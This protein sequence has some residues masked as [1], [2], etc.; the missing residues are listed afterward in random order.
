MKVVLLGSGNVATHLGV[1]LKK[2]GHTLLQLFNPTRKHATAL[3]RRLNCP[4]VTRV[5][6]I[7]TTGDIYVL[8][9]KDEAI[10]PLLKQLPFVPRMIVHTSGSVG[11]EVFG[12][13]FSA[14]GV[15]YPLQTFSKLSPETPATIPFCIEAN[16]RKSE[17]LLTRMA[18][19][20][21]PLVYKMTSEQRKSVHVAA[22]FANNFSNHMFTLSEKILTGKKL[23]F[24]LMLPLIEETVERLKHARPARVQTGPARRGDLSILRAHLDWLRGDPELRDLYD[25]IS[26]SIIAYYRKEK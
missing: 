22:V 24:E 19:S 17:Q 2:K 6:A 26:K 5:S 12:K 13:N 20:L 16:S 7:D 8:A 11:L 1:L 25:R 14:F 4:L 15:L 21:S 18:R 9:I 23:P 3:A 10:G